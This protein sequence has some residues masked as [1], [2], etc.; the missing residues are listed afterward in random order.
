[1]LLQ[2]QFMASIQRTWEVGSRVQVRCIVLLG[3]GAVTGI[4]G[5]HTYARWLEP[6][7]I[8]TVTDSAKCA[9]VQPHEPLAP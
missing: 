7:T 3:G 5:G 8:S 1:V 9:V 6:A 4:H 2:S